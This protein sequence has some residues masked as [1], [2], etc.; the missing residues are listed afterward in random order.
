M[1]FSISRTFAAA[2]VVTTMSALLMPVDA[3]VS[4]NEVIGPMDAQVLPVETMPLVDVLKIAKEK[5]DE[6]KEKIDSGDFTPPEGSPLAALGSSGRRRAKEGMTLR[7]KQVMDEEG[8][9][10][11]PGH[12]RLDTLVPGDVD[13]MMA[14]ARNGKG[15]KG[16]RGPSSCGD[17]AFRIILAFAPDIGPIS[18]D[19]EQISSVVYGIVLN[20]KKTP[21]VVVDGKSFIKFLE[22]ISGIEYLFGSA[23]GL[24]NAVSESLAIAYCN[25]GVDYLSFNPAARRRDLTEILDF[26]QFTASGGIGFTPV[27]LAGIHVITGTAQSLSTNINGGNL[28]YLYPGFTPLGSLAAAFIPYTEEAACNLADQFELIVEL[29]LEFGLL[30]RLFI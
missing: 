12:R 2:L 17:Y 19:V 8:I 10:R 26:N 11:K 23:A 18:T 20:F 15:S 6:I 14:A 16:S 28:Y 5:S 1:K 21:D 30:E 13:T 3:Q 22:G 24:C 25:Y 27:G 4:E 29:I 9:Q 7:G